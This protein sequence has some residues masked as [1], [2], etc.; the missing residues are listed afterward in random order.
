METFKPIKKPVETLKVVS[1]TADLIVIKLPAPKEK[2]FHGSKK[3][4]RDPLTE[5][6]QLL[7]IYKDHMEMQVEIPWLELYP[8]TEK[9][10]ASLYISEKKE[11]QTRT[12]YFTDWLNMSKILHSINHGTKLFIFERKNKAKKT[13]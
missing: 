12:L 2:L 5:I 9:E 6:P 8:G 11:K 4:Y 1:A 7:K 10:A 13:T 3:P